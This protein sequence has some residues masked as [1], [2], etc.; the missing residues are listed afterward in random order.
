MFSLGQVTFF[1]A[2]LLKEISLQKSQGKGKQPE[3]WDVVKRDS[4]TF[5][6]CVPPPPPRIVTKSWLSLVDASIRWPPQV[7]GV[8]DPTL[9]VQ[10][11]DLL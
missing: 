11:K 6:T 10:A 7:E 9:G 2:E 3:F 1:S 5:N 4:V 8:R